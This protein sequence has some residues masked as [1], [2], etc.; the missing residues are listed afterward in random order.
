[1]RA[2]NWDEILKLVSFERYHATRLVFLNVYP[3]FLLV[4]HDWMLSSDGGTV[5]YAARI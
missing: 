3:A 2:E 4:T 1:M 5:Y